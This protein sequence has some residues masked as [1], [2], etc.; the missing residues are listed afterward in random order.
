[1][2]KGKYLRFML[3]LLSMVLVFLSAACSSDT[4]NTNSNGQVPP[5]SGS[6]TGTEPALPDQLPDKY[7]PAIELTTASYYFS[8]IKFPQGEDI[9]HN[10]WTRALE[11]DY[12]IKVKH[13]WSVPY[14][15]F[16]KKMNLTISSGD[17][18]DISL[19]TPTQFKQLHESGLIEDMTDYYEKLAPDAVKKVM[20]EAGEEVKQSAMLDG[21]LMGIPFTGLAKEQVSIL[22]IREDWRNTLNLP[23]PT[24]LDNLLQIIA[25]FTE[26]DPDRNGQADTIGLGLDKDLASAKSF[27]NAFHAYRDI[28]I[29]DD[30]GK[31]AYSSIQPEMKTALEALQ[32][33]YSSGHLDKEFGV[34]NAT[35]L[36]QHITASKLGVFFGTM[37]AGVTPLGN[38]RDIDPAAEWKAYP[39]PSVD[40]EPLLYQHDLNIFYGYWVVKKG[41]KHPEAVFKLLE[42][43]LN[44]F[45]FNTSDDVF[46]N[47]NEAPDNNTLWMYAPMKMYRSEKNVSVYRNLKPLLEGTGGDVNQLTPE[48]RSIYNNIL[49]YREGDLQFWGQ[50]LSFGPNGGGKVIDQIMRNNQY[51]PT[52]F[53]TAPMQVMTDRM[54]QLEKMEAEAFTKIIQG[55]PISKFD[56]F[57]ADWKKAG[58]EDITNA[59]N[60]WYM[61]K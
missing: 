52:Q 40:E 19:V 25:A 20:Q 22:W 60:E 37:N 56:S 27:M 44:S 9:N 11:K 2:K 18:P 54:S 50:D 24:T 43:W 31:L 53:I 5:A 35:Q 57:V 41:V 26:S 29:E 3:T 38:T 4:D 34:K 45:Y 23:E 48:E 36:A 55:A 13:L 10:V 17:L 30:S 61:G 47:F 21:R 59:V 8:G 58:G 28:W 49:K 42:K 33:L 12:G 16:E 6:T 7:D 14:G 15:D 1:M 46:T 51:K 39:V 32:Q